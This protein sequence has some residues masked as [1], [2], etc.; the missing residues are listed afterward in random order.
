[1][2]KTL[3]ICFLS[4]LV[5]LSGCA[6][7]VPAFGGLVMA[8][9]ESRIEIAELWEEGKEESIEGEKQI[10][11]GRK[12]VEKGRSDLRTGEQLIAAGN[13]EVQTNRQAYQA[14]HQTATGI[15]SGQGALERVKKLKE[16]AS[17]WEEGEERIAE[18]NNL[19]QRGNEKIEE[20]ETQISEGQKL[21]ESGR[22]KMQD[23]EK[24]YQTK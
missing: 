9:G 21:I 19:I 14:L 16:I 17:D 13:V 22:D 1:M 6:T 12:L 20:G 3:L 8:D 11:Y 23:A 24:R 18:G 10:R 7:K 5:S 15:D 4:G 2:K